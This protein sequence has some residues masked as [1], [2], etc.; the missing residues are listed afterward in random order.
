MDMRIENVDP[1]LHRDFKTI[2]AARGTNMR[3][4]VLALM[5]AFVA[6]HGDKLDLG[7][8]PKRAKNGR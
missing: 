7:S 2:C 6:K 5:I 1:T 8:E 3:E 4:Q